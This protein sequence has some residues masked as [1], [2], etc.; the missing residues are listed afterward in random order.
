MSNKTIDDGPVSVCVIRILFTKDKILPFSNYNVRI[1]N[2]LQQFAAHRLR[3]TALERCSA[4]F[5]ARAHPN[6]SKNTWRH[7]TNFHLAKKEYETVHG[8]KYASTYKYLP[9]KSAP[10]WKKKK[11]NTCWI[12]LSM[13]NQCVYIYILRILNMKDKILLFSTYN[14]RIQL[15]TKIHGTPENLW[16]HTVCGTLLFSLLIILIYFWLQQA[17]VIY[18]FYIFMDGSL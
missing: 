16:Q 18:Y 14:V 12:K 4:T 9:Y 7:T 1:Y 5:F 11:R 3:N 15:L 13:M 10:I 6:L 2:F 8:H 17:V